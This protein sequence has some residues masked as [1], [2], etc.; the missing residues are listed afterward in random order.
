MAVELE[1]SKSDFIQVLWS[2]HS[3]CNSC[4][5]PKLVTAIHLRGQ[6]NVFRLCPGC[7]SK[8]EAKASESIEAFRS[9]ASKPDVQMH[10]EPDKPAF[11]RKIMD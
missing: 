6:Q 4:G 1:K 2:E 10:D 7:I 9:T 11:L 8:I 3:Y 5:E